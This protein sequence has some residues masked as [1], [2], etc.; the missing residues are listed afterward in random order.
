MRQL[1]E[2]LDRCDL[3]SLTTQ[4][5]KQQSFTP[6]VF[7][8]VVLLQ[9]FVTVRHKNI[10]NHGRISRLKHCGRFETIRV[11]DV[12]KCQVIVVAVR[13]VSADDVLENRI[14]AS[15]RYLRMVATPLGRVL[16]GK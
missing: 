6:Q 13:L 15:K 7:P 8:Y 11:V 1:T 5:S 12:E 4:F 2:A 16:Q 14:L 3:L 9:L 10:E